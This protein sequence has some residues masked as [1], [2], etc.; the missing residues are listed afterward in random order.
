MGFFS[1]KDQEGIT[2][3]IKTT[4]RHPAYKAPAMYED[5]ALVQLVDRVTFTTNIR[6]ACLYQNY[7]NVPP[8]AWVSGWGVTAYSK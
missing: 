7:G 3:I 8:K 6:P 4:I 2:V 5:I 1:L